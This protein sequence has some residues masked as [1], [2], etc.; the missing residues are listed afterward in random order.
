MRSRPY[1]DLH[2]SEMLSQAAVFGASTLLA[3][4]AAIVVPRWRG[5]RSFVRR[6]RRVVA[7][8]AAIGTVG[9]AAF[10]WFVRPQIEIVRMSP[11]KKWQI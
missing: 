10:A 4:L 11:P 2:R 6:W 5:L 3:V 1:F 9:L 8:L 7:V